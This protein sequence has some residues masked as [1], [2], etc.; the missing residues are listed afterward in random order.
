M[1]NNPAAKDPKSI[2][3]KQPTETSQM[4]ILLI[5]RMARKSRQKTRQELIVGAWVHLVCAIF[6]IGGIFIGIDAAQRAAF[7]AALVW[8][9]AGAWVCQRGMWAEPPAGDA[10]LESGAAFLRRELQR[11]RDLFGRSFVWRFCP[12]LFTLAAAFVPLLLYTAFPIPKAL[13]YMIPSYTVL[14]AVCFIAVVVERN[15]KKRDLQRELDELDAIERQN[16]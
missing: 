9:M 14:A 4:S 13:L 1:E 15:R 7:A 11:R 2:W 8:C 3:Q 6:A 10:G 12:V 16:R 5:H